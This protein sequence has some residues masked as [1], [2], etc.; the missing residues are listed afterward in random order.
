MNTRVEDEVQ[1]SGRRTTA[2]D[3]AAVDRICHEVRRPLAAIQA[4]AELLQDQLCGPLNEKQLEQVGVVVTNARGLARL[5]EELHEAHAALTGLLEPRFE[6]R[7]LEECL[8]ALA[9]EYD[10]RVRA[11]GRRLALATSGPLLHPR[12]DE[13]L[14]AAALR[15]VV[16][17]ALAYA[18]E[19]G[20][21]RIE[22]A[23]TRRGARIRVHDA[24]PGMQ[25]EDSERAFECFTRGAPPAG[26]PARGVGLGLPVC[27]AI[28]EAL[29]GS[30]RARARHPRGL[31]L[32]IELPCAEARAD[33]RAPRD[34]TG[35]RAA[36]NQERSP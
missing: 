19:G 6:E 24:G 9:A 36:S 29:G 17:N 23:S 18:G 15:R 5:V 27:R 14:L 11:D 1:R 7:D 34:R 8:T 20:E 16:D 30:V 10:E 31:T 12:V 22:L 25:P 33:G 13:R 4:Y 32:E 2:L 26:A 21:V 3:R 35:G 28:V